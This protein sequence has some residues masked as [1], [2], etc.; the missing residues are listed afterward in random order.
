MFP[1]LCYNILLSLQKLTQY[2]VN[3]TTIKFLNSNDF[4]T[5]HVLPHILVRVTPVNWLLIVISC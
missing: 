3:M 5:G 2:I 1:P 4:R